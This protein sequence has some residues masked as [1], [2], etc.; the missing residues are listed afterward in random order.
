MAVFPI[1]RIAMEMH[2]GKDEHAIGFNAEENA[3]RKS[4]HKAAADFRLDFR[5]HSR[6]VGNVLDRGENLSGEIRPETG[7]A[8]FVACCRLDKLLDCLW[9]KGA[10]HTPKRRWIRASTSSREIGLMRP[11][12]SSSRR[13]VATTPHW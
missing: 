5:P 13:R 12:R 10:A 9:M 7:I 6:V 8:C 11:E 2:D 3:K 1:V 4:M